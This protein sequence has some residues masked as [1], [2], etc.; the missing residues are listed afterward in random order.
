MIIIYSMKIPVCSNCETPL[1]RKTR[2]LAFRCMCDE[3]IRIIPF[4]LDWEEHSHIKYLSI[5]ERVTEY[6]QHSKQ[7]NRAEAKPAME[8]GGCSFGVKDIG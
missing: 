7:S 8:S 2:H 1:A 4:E 5:L 3:D 6:E